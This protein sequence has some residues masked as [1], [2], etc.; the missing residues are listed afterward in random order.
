MEI[1]F[2]QV[3]FQIINFSVVLYLLNRVLYKPVMNLLD[4]RAKKINES[5]AIADKNIK[6]TEESEKFKKAEIAKVRKEASIIL[7]TAE[8]EAKAKADKIIQE[9]KA[10][11]KAESVAMLN[12]TVKEIES[13]KAKADKAISTLA[14]KQAQSALGSSL[15][16][17]EIEAITTS[18]LKTK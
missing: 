8:K 18:M 10:K 12:S 13:N 16:A 3:L 11:A 17:K 9:A 14:T 2:T 5:M 4:E 1:N 6:A 7:A 15:T